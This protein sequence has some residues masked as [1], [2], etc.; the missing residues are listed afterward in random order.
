[1]TKWGGVMAKDCKYQVG[2][3]YSVVGGGV[4]PSVG[5]LDLEKS[6]VLIT[7]FTADSSYPYEGYICLYTGL[8]VDK[9]SYLYKSIKDFSP[10][11]KI[12]ILSR[13]AM[14]GRHESNPN[15]RLAN[16]IFESSPISFSS[17]SMPTVKYGSFSRKILFS[18]GIMWIVF[19]LVELFAYKICEFIF[20]NKLPETLSE[21]FSCA[22]MIW[23]IP[24]SLKMI[25][26]FSA[27]GVGISAPAL[28]YIFDEE[29]SFP[30]KNS[31]FTFNNP[32]GWVTRNG[33]EIEIT[34]IVDSFDDVQVV[35]YIIESWGIPNDDET[36]HC[37]KK[38]RAS[39][40]LY[41]ELKSFDGLPC[42]DDARIHAGRL[43][44]KKKRKFTNVMR[45]AAQNHEA[46]CVE[47]RN[48][49]AIYYSANND[50]NAD[51]FIERRNPAFSFLKSKI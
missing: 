45:A 10:P 26:D 4:L 46:D 23:L 18:M 28:D 39:W 42:H 38:V 24:M 29:K 21:V 44:N 25:D 30:G 33:N 36:L 51:T 13:W 9:S 16:R 14:N 15:I 31:G 47:S 49:A 43:F 50:L 19:P 2:C 27:D 5:C 22:F 20:K 11:K 12:R 35:G 8:D 7:K 17:C 34:N 6:R 41:G 3:L 32:Y 48:P 37:E 1:M 40:N